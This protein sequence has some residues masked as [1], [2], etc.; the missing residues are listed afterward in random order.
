[1]RRLVLGIA[2]RVYNWRPLK[3]LRSRLHERVLR[4]VRHALAENNQTHQLQALLSAANE[5]I[6]ANY[7][8]LARTGGFLVSSTDRLTASTDRLTATGNRLSATGERLSATGE[9]LSATGEHL[10]ASGDSLRVAGDRVERNLADTVSRVLAQDREFASIFE[11]LNWSQDVLRHIQ[12]QND[13]SRELMF[14]L[15]EL[16]CLKPQFKRLLENVLEGEI[17]AEIL[18]HEDYFFESLLR[19]A[20]S[21]GSG[22][23]ELGGYLESIASKMERCRTGVRA[24]VTP[25]NDARPLRVLLVSGMFPSY[26][27]AGGLR[28]FDFITEHGRRHEIDLYAWYDEA[29]DKDSLEQ[30]RP[31]LRRVRL[32]T[33]SGFSA[34]DAEDW[35]GRGGGAAYDVI[36]F[37]FPQSIPLIAPL[38]KFGRRT[39]YTMM[40]CV[41][42]RDAIDLSL[43]VRSQWPGER[44][45]E[46]MALFLRNLN[47]ECEA[48]L[49]AD[50]IIGMI[51]KDCEQARRLGARRV[52]LVPTG[53]SKRFFPPELRDRAKAWERN[54]AA[55]SPHG[56]QVVSFVGYYGHYPNV[57]ALD[58]YLNKVHPIVRSY[59]PGYTFEIIGEG[60]LSAIRNRVGQDPSVRFTGRVESIAESLIDSA[61]CVSPLISG[62]GF[63]GKINQYS[64]VG[65][66]T[67]S[68]SIGVC[69]LPYVHESSVL[70]ADTPLDFARQV[71]RLLTDHELHER[72]TEGAI[73]V[74]ETCFDW[75]SICN[76]I[77]SEIYAQ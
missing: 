31:S 29:Q 17:L 40:E 32:V 30:L 69:G 34:P 58:W 76:R 52:H 73:R 8:R 49:T 51:P 37:E 42:R 48:F 56:T 54:G 57:D 74:V 12:H 41:T 75:T 19:V 55:F 67:V 50:D 14:R 44:L 23:F 63:R 65:K 1:M 2:K 66:P 68:T 64:A 45:G 53:I 28:V 60:D 61:A 72:V 25:M 39:I 13:Q 77:E 9:K 35:I 22:Y 5:R 47:D 46:K 4:I 20:V 24:D 43:G 62:S 59:C 26:M 70:V 10:S 27:H 38:S 11:R 15:R 71:A 36:H 16:S 21:N 18:P 6:D 33:N 3:F 7:D